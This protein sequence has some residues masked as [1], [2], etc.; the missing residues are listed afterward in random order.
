VAQARQHWKAR[1][2]LLDTTRLVFVDETGT[3]TKM[4]RTHGRCRRGQRLIGKAPWGHWKTTTFTAGLRCDGLVAPW[5]L[6]G[7]MNGEA[8]LVY[9][10][11]VLAPSLSEGDIVVIDNL[12]AHKVEGVRAAIEA[13]GAILLYLPPYSPDLNP[14]E[15]AFAKL[16]TLLRKAAARTTDS[17][18]DAIAQVLGAFT[19]N[20]CANYLGHAGYASS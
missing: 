13:C 6:D 9:V 11:Q 12:S 1:Q 8:F 18:W 2:A 15:M 5:V 10:E 7:P 14:I 19:P 4:V 20:E 17:L 3:T 16:K